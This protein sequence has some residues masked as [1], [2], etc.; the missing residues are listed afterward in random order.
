MVYVAGLTELA[1]TLHPALAVKATGKPEVALAATV[2]VSFFFACGGMN[3][4]K[5]I[6]CGWGSW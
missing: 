3:E 5:A 1:G 6:V 4:V 2:K